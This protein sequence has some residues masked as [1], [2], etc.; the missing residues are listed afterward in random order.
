MEK[1]ILERISALGGDV[2]NVKGN[3]LAEDLLSIRFNTVLY[4]KPIDTP[5]AKADEEEPIY[6]LGNFVNKYLD[7]YH[8]DQDAF[9]EKMFEEYYSLSD[10]ARGQDFW[11][12]ES[13][14]PF[15]VGTE[16]YNEWNSDFVDI[17]ESGGLDEIIQVTNNR[18]PGF[19]KIIYSY[20][21]P[22]EYYVCLSDPNPDNPTVWGTDHETYFNEFTKCTLKEHFDSYMTQ[23]ELKE[24]VIKALKKEL[25]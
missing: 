5:W 21:F 12:A 14:T 3:S 7:L 1:C 8:S 23:S 19:V 20:G 22:D 11:I 6:G 13:F 2:S 9:F 16:S 10:E 24:I 18:T 4:P 17:L 15:E 25:L